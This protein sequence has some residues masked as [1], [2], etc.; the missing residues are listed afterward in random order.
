MRSIRSRQEAETADA[1][2]GAARCPGTGHHVILRGL[3]RGQIVADAQDREA[4]AG[5]LGAL[6]A[7]AGT[8]GLRLG[9]C[10]SSGG[11]RSTAPGPSPT[12]VFA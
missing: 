4:F 6:A 3:E 10:P 9:Y 11:G 5:R 12:P 7:A 1:S 8:M 2:P